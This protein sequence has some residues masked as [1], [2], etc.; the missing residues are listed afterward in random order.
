MIEVGIQRDWADWVQWIISVAGA[1]AGLFAA[2]KGV[3]V[4]RKISK[5]SSEQV[6]LAKES[7]DLQKERIDLQKERIVLLRR[8]AAEVLFEAYKKW[9]AE[10]QKHIAPS[11]T[12]EYSHEYRLRHAFLYLEAVL[13][14][15]AQSDELEKWKG[16]VR[17]ALRGLDLS[18]VSETSEVFR[19]IQSPDLREIVRERTPSVKFKLIRQTSVRQTL[20]LLTKMFVHPLSFTKE[21]L[22]SKASPRSNPL[23]R[24]RVYAP[25]D[26]RRSSPVIHAPQQPDFARRAVIPVRRTANPGCRTAHYWSAGMGVVRVLRHP[27]PIPCPPART[28]IRPGLAGGRSPSIE[29]P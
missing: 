13:F 20:C 29:A 12:G 27:T 14:Q 17:D 3:P 22:D 15:A 1:G 7:L 19:S 11:G 28:A 10:A 23:P 9:N 6:E 21:V 26:C 24:R 18:Q 16:T 2:I 25:A 4:L 8:N 5:S